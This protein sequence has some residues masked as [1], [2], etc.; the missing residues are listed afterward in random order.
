MCVP[1]DVGQPFPHDLSGAMAGRA[2]LTSLQSRDEGKQFILKDII[3][4]DFDYIISLQKHVEH[5][6]HVRTAVDSIP[7]RHIFVFPYLEKGLLHV[8]T[9]SLCPVAKKVIIRDALAGLA[10]LHGKHIIHPGQSLSY[11]TVTCE[12]T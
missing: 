8:D 10:D 1:R 12:L 9:A 2:I 6:P 3:E 11:R 4:G 5:S 7:E